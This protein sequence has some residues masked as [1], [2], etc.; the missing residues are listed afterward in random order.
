MGEEDCT[1]S[2]K[3]V[4]IG[5]YFGRNVIDMGLLG[6]GRRVSIKFY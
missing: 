3:N 5:S 2:L 4:H 1:T 6:N